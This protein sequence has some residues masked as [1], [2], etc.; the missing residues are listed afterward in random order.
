MKDGSGGGSKV[1]LEVEGGGGILD[2]RWNRGGESISM[3][4][5]FGGEC[6]GTV[7][8]ASDGIETDRLACATDGAKSSIVCTL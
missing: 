7:D 6:M 5:L 4:E 8:M 2:T 3:A 1:R